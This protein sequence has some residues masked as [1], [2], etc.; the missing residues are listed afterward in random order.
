MIDFMMT[1]WSFPAMHL[2]LS[3]FPLGLV[4]GLLVGWGTGKLK[5]T[6]DLKVGYTRK[7][8]HFAIFSLAGIIGGIGGFPAVQVFGAS[9]GVLVFYAVWRGYE[10]RLYS[11]LARPSDR[12]H[13]TFYILV[14][15]FMTA[16]GGMVGNIFFGPCAMIGYITTGWGDAV[17]EPVGT[18]WGKHKYR[19]LTLTGI[20]SY[21]SVEGSLGVFIAAFTGCLFLLMAGYSLPVEHMLLYSLILALVTTLVEAVTFHSLD[22]FTIQVI[23]SGVGYWL[24]A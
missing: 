23:T 24:I 17:G 11:A 6:Y 21:R 13:E 22:N 14:P 7:I 5:A 9:I 15:F 18:R 8:F 3:V 19:V 20:K 2:W 12:P 1:R 4:V 10:S 16:L